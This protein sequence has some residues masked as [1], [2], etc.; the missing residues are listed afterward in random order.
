M[1]GKTRGLGVRQ[2]VLGRPERGSLRFIL[3]T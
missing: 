2:N 3:C 1:G